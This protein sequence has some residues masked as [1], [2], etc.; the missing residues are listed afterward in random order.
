[1]AWGSAW[2]EK[3]NRRGSRN[4]LWGN[5]PDAVGGQEVVVG[6]HG[7]MTVPASLNPPL[8]ARNELQCPKSCSGL[9]TGISQNQSKVCW[10]H[11]CFGTE[12]LL[13][14]YL[15]QLV[16]LFGGSWLCSIT[17][18]KY[19]VH[20]YSLYPFALPTEIPLGG[21]S[22]AAL[23]HWADGTSEAQL[24]LLLPDFP[25][26]PGAGCCILAHSLVLWHIAG[27]FHG[28]HGVLHHCPGKLLMGAH[29]RRPWHL[30]GGED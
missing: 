6:R 25:S 3:E 30:P 29:C 20:W 16:W 2:E 13:T 5:T 23:H 11:A 27:A 28:W 9:L 18:S 21:F 22:R 10:L 12:P 7:D 17:L 8:G 19:I 26:P 14:E 1:M 4:R 24:F 15:L